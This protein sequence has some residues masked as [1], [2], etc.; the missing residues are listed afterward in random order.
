MCKYKMRSGVLEGRDFLGEGRG[1]M[2]SDKA[3]K[4]KNN[5]KGDVGEVGGWVRGERDKGGIDSILSAACRMLWLSQRLASVSKSFPQ[6][7]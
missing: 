1:G 6:H 7:G 3:L 4:G 2:K 5:M